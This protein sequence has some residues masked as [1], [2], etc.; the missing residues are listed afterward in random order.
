MSNHGGNAPFILE[1][2]E[3]ED[4]VSIN[5]E[6][7]TYGEE[8]PDAVSDNY[9]SNEA[10]YDS[11]IQQEYRDEER[12]YYPESRGEDSSTYSNYTRSETSS[13]RHHED[14][15]RLEDE[16]SRSHDQVRD[17]DYYD[18]EKQEPEQD[19]QKLGDRE[20]SP[21]TYKRLLLEKITRSEEQ[22][23]IQ[24]ENERL[25]LQQQQQHQEE[26]Q[27]ENQIRERQQQEQEEK[28]RENQI[29]ERQQQEQEEQLRLMQERLREDQRNML[30]KRLSRRSLKE[31]SKCLR[32]SPRSAPVSIQVDI[33]VPVFQQRAVRNRVQQ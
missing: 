14:D 25:R 16:I 11:S 6:S 24:K 28:Q 4:Y 30:Q 9:Q 27:R 19:S 10:P 31:Q 17:Q 29:R 3:E 32:G 2:E 5:P 20:M 12:R 15:E 1:D 22:D 33:Q 8:R 26:Q 7:S 23:R 13:M 18:H 21:K